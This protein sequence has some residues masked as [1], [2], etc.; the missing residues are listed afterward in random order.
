M[1]KLMLGMS[2]FAVLFVAGPASAA[3]QQ[4]L[5]DRLVS[6]AGISESEA[7]Q[8]LDRVIESIKAELQEGNAITI[9]NFGKFHVAKRDARQGRNPRTGEAI[10][11][12]AKRYPRFTSS[13]SFKRE[14]NA[15]V[16]SDSSQQAMAKEVDNSTTK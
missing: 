5:V 3:G 13:D 6:Q 12:P 7:K 1:N 8:Q 11:I 4:G 16:L 14:I 2:F 10:A 15:D 9:R